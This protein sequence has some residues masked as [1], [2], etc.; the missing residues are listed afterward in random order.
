MLNTREFIADFLVVPD[1][2][3]TSKAMSEIDNSWRKYG[4]PHAVFFGSHW[5]IFFDEK[6]YLENAIKWLR[7]NNVTYK[8]CKVKI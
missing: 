2:G 1:G 7:K 6:E 5:M 8:K 3:G 4:V